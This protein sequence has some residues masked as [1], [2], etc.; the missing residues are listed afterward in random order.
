MLPCQIVI[1]Y[2]FNRGPALNIISPSKDVVHLP[3]TTR[4]MSVAEKSIQA[5]SNVRQPPPVMFASL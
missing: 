3:H 5:G 2:M 1:R 4:V